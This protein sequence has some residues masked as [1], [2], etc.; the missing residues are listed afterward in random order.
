MKRVRK[1]VSNWMRMVCFA[2]LLS[3]D[4]ETAARRLGITKF[5][6]QQETWHLFKVLD[7]TNEWRAA[8]KL[9]VVKIDY[10]KIPDWLSVDEVKIIP[11][12]TCVIGRGIS[13]TCGILLIH[14]L[15][16]LQT[17]IRFLGTRRS[18]TACRCQDGRG[19]L[20]RNSLLLRNLT[21]N[22]LKA[23]MFFH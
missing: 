17:R 2:L 12:M 3:P 9:G 7:V 10:E 16:F 23:R 8:M 20:G 18:T 14:L 6:L 21:L 22:S 11:G 13:M 19:H 4:R 1:R 5:A 15:H